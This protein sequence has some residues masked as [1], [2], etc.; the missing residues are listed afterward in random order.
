MF[1]ER[2]LDFAELLP[3]AIRL[4][5]SLCAEVVTEKFAE[6][7]VFSQRLCVGNI[8]FLR[9]II[10]AIM[11]PVEAEL[12]PVGTTMTSSVQTVLKNLTS[13]IQC[14]ANQ[15]TFSEAKASYV[16]NELFI[17]KEKDRVNEFLDG[18]IAIEEGEPSA[19]ITF[20]RYKMAFSRVV[21]SAYILG[22]EDL[23]L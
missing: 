19:P 9:Y 1:I 18:I 8:I 17:E 12:L 5:C 23:R 4:C 10:P 15:T 21:V 16:L 20:E 2:I 22:P 13:S 6:D 7:E 14:L 3:E 11:S